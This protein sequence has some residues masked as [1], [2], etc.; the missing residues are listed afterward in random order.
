[1]RPMAREL[2]PT[3]MSTLIDPSVDAT[4]NTDVKP[5]AYDDEAYVQAG[6]STFIAIVLNDSVTYNDATTTR[7]GP[8]GQLRRR[9][10]A[11]P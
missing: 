9:S 2:T 3:R 7:S 6:E 4:W 5:F 10:P 11:H 8:L 1:M